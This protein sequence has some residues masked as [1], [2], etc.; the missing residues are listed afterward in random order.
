MRTAPTGD[1]LQE[2][3][4]QG[5]QIL[6][7]WGGEAFYNSKNLDDDDKVL[8]IKHYKLLALL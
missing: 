4:E 8:L 7:A 6:E 3:K 1:N 2:S 5:Y